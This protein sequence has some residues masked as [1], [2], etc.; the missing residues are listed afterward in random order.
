M[1]PTGVY[2]GKPSRIY[3]TNVNDTTYRKVSHGEGGE[4]GEADPSL[5][6]DGAEL[7]FRGGCVWKPRSTYTRSGSEN[8]SRVGSAGLQRDMVSALVP[9]PDRRQIL[10]CAIKNTALH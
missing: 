8:Q 6:P 3:L 5:L 2:A 4:L 10:S 9:R 1:K 7:A